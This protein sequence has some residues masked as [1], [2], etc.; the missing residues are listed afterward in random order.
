M[1]EYYI[2]LMSGTSVDAIDAV[3]VD[4]EQASRPVLV[5]AIN[6]PIDDSQRQH[7]LSICSK[8]KHATLHDSATLDH[9]LG[10]LFTGA[11]NTLLKQSGLEHN[12][13]RAIGS[14]GQTILH[15]PNSTP[16]YTIQIGDANIIAEKTGITT[17]ADFR[18][19]D[20]A[21]G[22]QG[23][24]LVPAF[25]RAV[26]HSAEENRA[27]VNIGG[28]AN[29]TVLHADPGTPVCGFD[30]GPG[31]TLLDQ[32]IMKTQ[33]LAFDQGGQ[34]ASRGKVN[35]A[36]LDKLLDE[37][38]FQQAPPKSTGPELFNLDWLQSHPEIKQMSAEDV[39]N[40]LIELTAC[41]ITLAIQ[42]HAADTGR[43]LICGGGSHNTVLMSRLQV[44]ANPI[45]VTSTDELGV[46][47]DWV[48]AM[49]FAWMAQRTLALQS[50]NLP[51]VTGAESETILGAVYFG[52]KL[53]EK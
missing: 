53:T 29:M 5:H 22:G 37:P 23:A 40:T 24:P 50:S 39:Q 38:F 30:T 6:Q 15:N 20:M 21:A 49:A 42:L 1:P 4:L 32:W 17:V 8:G 44:L 27:I 16:A 2:G 34:F 33:G 45:P 28:I 52:K 14:H 7:I 51:S 25:H 35:Q 46:N 12:A 3:V 26:F 19:R 43:I 41:S 18:R 13:I 48:E 31:N 47:P 10:Y 9:T 36:L 11:V